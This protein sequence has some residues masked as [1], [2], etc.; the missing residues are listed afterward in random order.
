MP[1]EQPA[2]DLAKII[3]A[4]EEWE[5]GEETP[6]RALANMKTAGLALVLAS[7]PATAGPRRCPRAD[8]PRRDWRRSERRRSRTSWR[9]PT[10]SPSG[11]IHHVRGRPW[12][13]DSVWTMDASS[14]PSPPMSAPVLPLFPGSRL[15]AVLVVLATATTGRGAA[16]P[17]VDD[18][19]QPSRRGELSRRARRC[20]RDTSRA[21]LREAHEEVGLDPVLPRV[22]GELA[23]LNTIVSRSYI[24]PVVA[25][26]E[27]PPELTAQTGEVDRVLWTPIAELT[28]PGMYRP[29]AG[30]RRR[31]IDRC[32]SSSSTTRPCGARP[33]TCS[34][35]CWCRAAAVSATPEARAAGSSAG[36]T[37]PRRG[38]GW[39]SGN[40]SRSA[41]PNGRRAPCG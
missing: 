24:V 2:P 17:T 18:V 8:C 4:L 14:W 1:F 12:P 23:H 3:A 6:G 9:R 13:S 21:A 15:S 25:T 37:P 35:S 28:Q 19:A 10:D 41:A 26:L 29:S 34:S 36:S 16:D 39:W 33:P 7:S 22:I 11:R 38:R 31:S 30:E 20:G 27:A 32:T 40:R 5:R